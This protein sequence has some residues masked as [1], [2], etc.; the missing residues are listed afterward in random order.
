[1]EGGG[2]VVNFGDGL[3][4]HGK[5]SVK[6]AAV[7]GTEELTGKVDCGGGPGSSSDLDDEIIDSSD[8]S[9]DLN[10]YESWFTRSWT[11]THQGR[12][13]A[14]VFKLPPQ[15]LFGT[16]ISSMGIAAFISFEFGESRLLELKL[17]FLPF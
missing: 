10:S 4:V 3:V 11:L 2:A 15:S 6:D 1:M 14:H 12:F 5:E 16:I 8:K 9:L 13:L 7:V 17:D